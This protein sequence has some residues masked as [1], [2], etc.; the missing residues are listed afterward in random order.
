[1]ERDKLKGL[2]EEAIVNPK[3]K[4]GYYGGDKTAC[5]IASAWIAEEMGC[6]VRW[7]EGYWKEKGIWITSPANVIYATA[8]KEEVEGEIKR[9]PYKKA[10]ELAWEGEVV[11]L[12]AKSTIKGRSGHIAVVYP[13]RPGIDALMVC[14]VGW[15]NLIC[16]PDDKRSFGGGES[17]LTEGIYFHLT[18]EE[19][20]E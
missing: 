10:Q 19:S 3:F 8:L 9:V 13:T 14:N 20:G 4:R 15:D 7:M 2:C 5:N 16:P 17:Y 6:Y 1:M 11:I 18:K 12:T